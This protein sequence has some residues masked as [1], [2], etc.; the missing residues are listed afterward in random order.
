MHPTTWFSH[1]QRLFSASFTDVCFSWKDLE[2][3]YPLLKWIRREAYVQKRGSGAPIFWQIKN[4]TQTI[5]QTAFMRRGKCRY[6]RTIAGSES[7]V[8]KTWAY[9]FLCPVMNASSS[10]YHE[11]APWVWIVLCFDMLRI[12]F[13][14]NMVP[15]GKEGKQRVLRSGELGGGGSREK[16]VFYLDGSS[17]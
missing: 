17:F 10:F 1:R 8:C 9:L 7:L 3:P 12:T 13:W 2:L 16:K 4:L 5:F 6:Q 15:W 11:N 14:K